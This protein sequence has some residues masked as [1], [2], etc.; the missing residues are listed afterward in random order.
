MPEKIIQAFICAE[1]H[2][3][4]NHSGVSFK[5]I[6]RSVLANIYHGKKAQG[7]STITQQLVRLLFFNAKKTYIRKLK[8][9]LYA[10]L[11]ERQYTKEQIL[12]VYLNHVYFG[13]GIYGVSAAAKRFWGKE[14]SQLTVAQAATLA[15]IMRSPVHYSPISAPESSVRRRNYVLNWMHTLQYISQAE[16]QDAQNEELGIISLQQDILAPH[17]KEAIRIEL[18]ERFG[19]ELLYTGGLTIQSTLNVNMQKAAEHV[20]AEKIKSLKETMHPDIDGGMVSI[21]SSTGAL[22]VMIGGYDFSVSKFNRALQAKRQMGSIFKPFVYATALEK[23]YSFVDVM[24][25]EPIQIPVGSQ[26][27][28]PRNNT[29]KFTGPMTLAYALSYSNNIIPIKLLLAMGPQP[30]IDVATRCH[31]PG[32]IAQYASLAIGC[33][34]ASVLQV[35]ASFNVFPSNGLYV[36]PYYIVWVKDKLGNKIYRAQYHQERVLDSTV[37]SQ[38]AQVLTL[39]L[40][41]LK[42]NMK[43]VWFESGQV[44]GK[45]GTTNDS[46]T[47]W[48]CGA[49]QEYTTAVYVGT[50]DNKP[51]GEH[52]YGSKVSFPIWYH[53][54]KQLQNK[55]GTFFK[56]PSLHEVS[57]D[58]KTGTMT[59]DVHNPNIANLLL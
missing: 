25:D 53:F 23:G 27:W 58:L 50:D 31:I 33:V 4:F 13:H 35:A 48:F 21:E 7:A 44:L 29:R 5:G 8:E 22:K 20:F 37:V 16:L 43:D 26:L 1:D 12:E 57:I 11:I 30:I 18:E 32:P 2:T 47:C 59:R 3:F 41:R 52:V 54:H 24:V 45:T 9:Q 38:V 51:L 46:R 39:S 36:Q 40:D 10:I 17:L 56:D 34:D 15:S 6:V 14:L 42:K 28:E 55:P 19:K 49:T